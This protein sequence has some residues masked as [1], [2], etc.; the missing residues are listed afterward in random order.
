[1]KADGLAALLYEAFVMAVP[2][3]RQDIKF[4][5]DKHRAARGPISEGSQFL[6]VYDQTYGS[7]HLTSRL[8]EDGVLRQVLKTCLDL[9]EIEEAMKQSSESITGLEEIRKCL[10]NPGVSL[11]LVG[12]QLAQ[13][14]AAG[15]RVQVI[16]PGSKG[17]STH[18][19]NEEFEVQKAQFHPSVNGLAYR[20]KY[21]TTTEE[22]VVEFLPITALVPVPGESRLG[23]YDYDLGEILEQSGGG[24]QTSCG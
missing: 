22:N 6:A 16:L 20:G 13:P 9:A 10:D 7:L 8:M 24:A 3:E 4:A 14:Q 12:G 18:R 15:S 17:L 5:A 2:F 19:N 21:I 23:Y 1:M 11:V